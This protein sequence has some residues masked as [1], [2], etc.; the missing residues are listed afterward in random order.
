M[1]LVSKSYKKRL[2]IPF[3][4][5][6]KAREWPSGAHTGLMFFPT[7]MWLSISIVPLSRWYSASRMLP[8]VSFSKSVPGPRS[9]A[10]AIV[11][12]SGDQEGWRSAY[13]SFVSR[14]NPEPSAFTINK[15]ESPPS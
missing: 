5:D 2:L 9:V 8:N 4:S 6:T 14:W 12:P 3:R 13:L 10:N 15:S 11:L 1:S 7:S